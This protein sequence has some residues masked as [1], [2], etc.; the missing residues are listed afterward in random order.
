MHVTS[1]K[2][3]LNDNDLEPRRGSRYYD[4]LYKV[5]PFVDLCANKFRV[6]YTPK[7]NLAFDEGGCPW[8]G[9]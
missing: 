2:F 9:S 7:M 1:V 4:P 5:R 3:T 8:K 6:I